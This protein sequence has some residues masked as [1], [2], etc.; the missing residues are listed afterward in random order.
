MRSCECESEL[1][2][3]LCEIGEMPWRGAQRPE[4]ERELKSEDE[5]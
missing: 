3:R 5:K 2:V 1:R 4:S